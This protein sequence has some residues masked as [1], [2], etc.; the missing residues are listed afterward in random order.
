MALRWQKTVLFLNRPWRDTGFIWKAA[1]SSLVFITACLFEYVECFPLSP[2]SLHTQVWHKTTYFSSHKSLEDFFY[3]YY[4]C[5]SGGGSHEALGLVELRLST[6][7]ELKCPDSY[8]YVLLSTCFLSAPSP[9]SHFPPS[10]S[11][12]FP[13]FFFLLPLFLT[14]LHHPDRRRRS[15]SSLPSGTERSQAWWQHRFVLTSH[16]WW[17]TRRLD[18]PSPLTSHHIRPHRSVWREQLYGRDL[19]PPLFPGLRQMSWITMQVQVD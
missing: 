12:I 18:L 17:R 11:S 5:T 1:S 13:S 6:K 14:S 2:Y 19:A 10:S 16:Q 9:L 8:L 3:Y 7:I 4:Y 15:R